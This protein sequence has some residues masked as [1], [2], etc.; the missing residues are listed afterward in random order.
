MKVLYKHCGQNVF[1]I[2]YWRG[3]VQAQNNYSMFVQYPY[4]GTYLLN[5][6]GVL[7]NKDGL[8]M[9]V[10]HELGALSLMWF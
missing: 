1:G 8:C 5:L 7:H 4:E 2:H 3:I 9:N 6:K 10:K